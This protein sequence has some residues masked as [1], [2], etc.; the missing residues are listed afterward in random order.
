VNGRGGNMRYKPG[1]SE[2][3][4]VLSEVHLYMPTI[5]AAAGQTVNLSLDQVQKIEV[6][7]RDRKRTT[8]SYVIGAIGYTLGAMAVALV[9][10]AATKSSC[11]F[12][13]AHD[14]T[15]T[16]WYAATEDQQR[17]ERSAVH[18]FRRS[19]GDQT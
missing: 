3:L 16:E 13:S 12:V 19:A 15:V 8:N 11:P 17:A 10:I 7:E 2:D 5:P 6:L 1:D 4:P 14:G 9:I 18:G